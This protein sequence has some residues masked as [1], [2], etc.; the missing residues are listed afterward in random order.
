MVVVV[1]VLLIDAVVVVIGK[2]PDS[3]NEYKRN[4][5][6]SC[7]DIPGSRSAWACSDP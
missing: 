7:L 4:A 6:S 5:A 3:L 1:V 2:E